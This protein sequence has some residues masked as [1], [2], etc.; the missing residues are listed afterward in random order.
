MYF[1]HA[2]GSSHDPGTDCTTMFDSLTPEASNLAFVPARR[3]S[4]IAV[5][6]QLSFSIILIVWMD[7]MAGSKPTSVPTGVDD[8]DTEG[9][10]IVLLGFAWTFERCHFVNRD[11]FGWW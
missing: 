9:A 5:K 2:I 8:A 7:R 10:A 11:F 1:E 6:C 3:G 4:I